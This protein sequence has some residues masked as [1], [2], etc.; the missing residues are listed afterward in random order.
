MQTS[1]FTR[2][3]R[4]TTFRFALDRTSKKSICPQCEKKTLVRY[5][6]SETGTYIADHYGRCDREANC[7]YFLNPYSDG[8]ARAMESDTANAFVHHR[9][10]K[11][12]IRA[13]QLEPA[14]IPVEVLN[15][16]LE[17]YEQNAFIQNLLNNIPFPFDAGKVEEVVSM[18]WLGTIAEGY[19][20]GAICFPFIDIA[21]AVRAIQVKEFDH[22]NHTTGTGFLHKMLEKQFES[23][24]QPNP[25][26]LNAYLKNEKIVSCLF[27]EHLLKQYPRNPIA[28]VEAPKTAIYGTLYFGPPSHPDNLLWLAVY[29]LSSLNLDR[30]KVLAGRKVVLFPD[31]SKTGNAY[32]QWSEKAKAFEAAMP[33]TRFKVSD[34]LERNA[35]DA[36]RV[37]GCDLADYLI[38]LDWKAFCEPEPASV[39]SAKS[40]PIETTFYSDKEAEAVFRNTH[41]HARAREAEL[42]PLIIRKN[43]ENNPAAGKAISE[44]IARLEGLPIPNEPIQL[45]QCSKIHDAQKF[46][47]SHL[48][49]LKRY[50]HKGAA[51]AFFDRLQALDSILNYKTK[52]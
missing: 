45:N 24:S 21:G 13:R 51:K 32:Q 43:A 27:G 12:P 39:K 16:T 28:L 19:R 18:Y 35:S 5:V 15:S 41:A 46:V 31:L 29:N 52:L 30:C 40:E 4:N 33:A 17:G 48:N 42:S 14:F 3:T 7:G 23:N 47:H 11:Q 22:L 2:F 6:D 1:H 50:P 10:Q 8:F 36:E 37:Q 25:D 20:K 9:P 26:W 34:L 49:F 38:K 44:L